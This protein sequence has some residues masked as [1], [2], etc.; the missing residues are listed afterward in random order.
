MTGDG[1]LLAMAVKCGASIGAPKA[2]GAPPLFVR[3]L[4]VAVRERRFAI[5]LDRIIGVV[6]SSKI[7]PLPFSPPPFEGLVLGGF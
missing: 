7:T 2:L 1:D 4:P 3:Y 5:P 6:E